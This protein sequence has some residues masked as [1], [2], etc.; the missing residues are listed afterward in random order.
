MTLALEI[1]YDG[2]AYHGW[3]T[4]KNAVTVQETLSKAIERATGAWPQPELSGC[5]RT[6]AGVSAARYIASF[7]TETPIPAD[8]FPM[9]IHAF[10]PPDISVR[11]AKIVPNGFHARFSCV[12]K[13]YVYRLYHSF[14]P[15][16]FE[17]NRA[18]FRPYP[19]N[20][21]LM[22]KAAADIVGTHDFSAFCATGSAVRSPVRT[23][24]YCDVSGNSEFVEIRI[25]ADGFL[26]NMVRIVAGTLV[27]VS[28]EK[29][30][31]DII[32]TLIASG[33]RTAAGITLPPC[34]LRLEQVWYGDE[35]GLE[36]IGP[37]TRLFF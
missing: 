20:V 6:D 31:P 23:V 18:A 26:Y 17:R 21:E 12:K 36:G 37:N 27:A 2:S 9:A 11:Q 15:H 14:L 13:E 33:D 4:Q 29:L 25:C 30:P 16:P 24:F 7:R 32:R 28:E 34:G 5:G 10:L 8:R 22:Q 19:F 3:Q 35:P 1:C